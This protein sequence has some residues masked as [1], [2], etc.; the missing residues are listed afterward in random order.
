MPLRLRRILIALVTFIGGLYFFLIYFLPLPPQIGGKD[1]Q[2]IHEQIT[3]GVMIV[4]SMAIGLGIIN[5]LMVHGM[6]LVKGGKRKAFSAALLLGMAITFVVEIGDFIES[7][8]ANNTWKQVQGLS[9]YAS[10]ANKEPKPAATEVLLTATTKLITATQT[11]DHYLSTINITDPLI[12]KDGE[13]FSA[14][15]TPIADALR[16]QRA[17]Q[18]TEQEIAQLQQLSP[19][20]QR[21]AT[22]NYE[23][24]RWKQSASLIKNGFFVPLGSSMFALLAFYIASAAYRSFRVRSVEAV[25]M[26]SAAILVILGQIPQ[27]PL[28]IS[29]DLPE[30]RKWL[31]DNVSTPAFRAINFAAI[32]AGLAMAVRM[33]LSLER[34]TMGD[35]T[36]TDS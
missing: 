10:S 29:D 7:E 8:R 13:L 33:W 23:N 2:A 5:L 3:L 30:L 20:A 19:L 11:P 22:W 32:I 27:G 34:S 36:T 9:A 14:A 31:L 18:F 4:G 17:S 24:T 16:G 21:I 25:L 6:V 15:L 28:Y 26:M 12:K 1:V 35:D